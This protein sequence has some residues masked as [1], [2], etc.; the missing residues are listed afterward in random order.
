[1]KPLQSR[2]EFTR[3]A[4]AALPGAALLSAAGRLGA[5]A[6]KPNSKFAGVQIGLN[7]PYSFGNPLMTA[8]EIL[9]QCVKLGLSGVELRTQ[10]VEQFLGVPADL[11]SPKKGVAKGSAAAT[12]E[13]LRDWRKKANLD[14]VKEFRARWENAGVK[15]EIGA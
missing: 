6:D 12:A 10:P 5:A 1:M 8:D 7:V 13:A 11:V 9:D 4:L 14:R 3:L 15:I 2:R